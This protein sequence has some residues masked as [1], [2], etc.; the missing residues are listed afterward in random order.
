MLT[1]LLLQSNL[2]LP[3]VSLRCLLFRC[4]DSM[5]QVH[6]MTVLDDWCEAALQKQQA[7]R[8]EQ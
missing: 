3:L 7:H 8:I 6:G 4:S 1:G 5:L 2:H